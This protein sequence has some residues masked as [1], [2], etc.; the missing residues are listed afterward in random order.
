MTYYDRTSGETIFECAAPKGQR[1]FLVA[2]LEGGV[3]RRL[4]MVRQ[5]GRWVARLL[6]PPGLVR[7]AFEVA[8]KLRCDPEAGTVR[9]ADGLR[10]SLSPVPAWSPTRPRVAVPRTSA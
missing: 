1:V 3:R 2:D 8:G 9:T 10:F 4:R 5:A 6:V 7:Y